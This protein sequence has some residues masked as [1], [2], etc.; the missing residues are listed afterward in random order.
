MK[1]GLK[2]P[3]AGAI[4]LRAATYFDF[5]GLPVV[6][7][8]IG[9]YQLIHEWGVLGNADWGDCAFAGG[10]H[11]I[12]LVTSEATNGVPAPFSTRTVLSNY[13]ALTHFDPN[14]GPSGD[15]PT[16]NGTDLGELADYWMTTGI[17]DDNGAHH[18]I[19]G[20]LDMNPGDLRELWT[21]TFLFQSVGMGF[22][23]PDS[24]QRQ[25]TLGE[26][27]DVVPGARIVGGHYVPCVGRDKEGYGLGVTWGKLQR[28]TPAFY[29]TY[30]NQGFCGLS[31]E[32][33]TKGRSIDGF[34]DKLLIA[35]FKKLQH[36]H[37]V[38]MALD[39]E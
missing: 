14:A 7:Q 16:D 12:M 37:H 19:V 30:N 36:H 24:A 38:H 4:P 33:I 1:L 28:F 11:Q 18:K 22:A 10:A 32:M 2:P 27:W 21:A 8:V 20:A 17:Y 9:H 25:F 34:D 13:S 29:Q 39:V 35:D 5:S 23:L 3:R 6:P 15:N 31:L 26:P